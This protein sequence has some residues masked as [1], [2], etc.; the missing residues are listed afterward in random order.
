M[1]A[2]AATDDDDDDASSAHVHLKGQLTYGAAPAAEWKGFW[3]YAPGTQVKGGPL[4][5]SYARVRDAR[6]DDLEGAAEATALDFGA[7][8]PE[9]WSGFYEGHFVLRLHGRE[10]EVSETFA[11]WRSGR[12]AARGAAESH[13]VT[14]HGRNSYGR[15]SLKGAV[16]RASGALTLGRTYA[17]TGRGR[18]GGRPGRPSKKQKAANDAAAAAA[19][20]SGAAEAAA[21][22]ADKADKAK[23]EPRSSARRK[24]APVF[25]PSR[26]SPTNG[27]ARLGKRPRAEGDDDASKSEDASNEDAPPPAAPRAKPATRSSSPS[28]KRKPD[29]RRAR[30]P[31]ARRKWHDDEGDDNDDD[32]EVVDEDDLLPANAEAGDDD[33]E[34]DDENDDA[35]GDAGSGGLLS[36]R[37][38]WQPATYDEETNEV[39]EGS[40]LRSSGLRDGLGACVALSH[41]GN[42]YEGQWRRGREHG[43]GALLTRDRRVVYD[44]DWADGKIHGKGIYF[45]PRGDVYCG[46]WRENAR[47]GF[48]RYVQAPPDRK[49]PRNGHVKRSGYTGEWRE[50][51]RHGRG[52]YDG[53]DGSRYD[54][55]W[56]A[57]RRHGRGT[58]TTADGATYEGQWHDDSVEGRGVAVY[59]CG[60]KYEGVFRHGLKEGRGSLSWPNGASYEGRF[61][62]D[63][64]DGQGALSIPKPVA[65]SASDDDAGAD[66][67]LLPLQL[68]SDLSRIHVKAGFDEDGG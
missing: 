51:A 61:R 34:N 24:R 20:P 68:K 2:A 18:G 65:I 21:A 29:K 30:K 39:Y 57:D 5:F 26:Q 66:G 16:G 19:A 14:G 47:H 13:G 41:R 1:S 52:R 46:E 32:D 48:G 40:V 7:A 49:S 6:A 11:L 31:R 43:R 53:P 9:R 42:V 62:D 45:F 50:N 59:A 15:F 28:G 44:G 17:S 22:A 8:A 33:D 37:Q 56:A 4:P 60:Q 35:S 58:L 55:E 23:P 25:H 67:W 63:K 27:Y 64:I 10:S 54:G 3:E 38:V 12:D 36:A